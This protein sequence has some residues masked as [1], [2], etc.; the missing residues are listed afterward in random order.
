MNKNW[1]Q[2]KE[3]FAETL[4]EPAAERSRFIV[5]RCAGDKDLEREIKSLLDSYNEANL[6]LESPAVVE[7]AE[8]FADESKRLR[9]GD[10][11][12]HYQI[13]KQI[14]KGGM[15]EVFLAQDTR[16]ERKVA[17]KILSDYF[18]DNR[19]NLKRFIRE[20]KTASSLNHPNIVI[21]HE[22]DEVDGMNFIVSEFIEGLT[23]TEIINKKTLSLA[24]V[25]DILIQIVKALVAAHTVGIIH[26]DIKPDNVMVRDDGI[27]KVLDFGLAKLVEKR[28]Q[29][30]DPNGKTLETIHTRSGMILGT[31][32]YMSPEQT[33]GKGIDKRTDIWSFGVLLYQFLTKKL[34]FDGETTSDLIAS[35]LKS[36]PTALNQIAPHLPL[37]IAKITEKCLQKNP[38]ERFQTAAELLTALTDFQQ[39]LK[40]SPKTEPL[41][42]QIS[43]QLKT[44]R[45][46]DPNLTKITA[47][48]S[49]KTKEAAESL[50]GRTFNQFKKRSTFSITTLIG[51]GL[52]LA[53]GYW[54]WTKIISPKQELNPFQNMRLSKLTYEG[55]SSDVTAISPDGKYIAYV[56]KSD[57]KQAMMVRQVSN[58]GVAEIIPP[59]DADYNGLSFSPDGNSI[60]YTSSKNIT[61]NDLYE[62]P[63]LGGSPQK[64]LSNI[65]P[66]F[67]FSPDGQKL[68]YFISERSLMISNMT[69]ESPQL[70]TTIELEYLPAQISW[71]PDGKAIVAVIYGKDAKFR[72]SEFSLE[73][74]SEKNISDFPWVRINGLKFLADGSG[75]ILAGRDLETQ[76]SQI[77]FVSYPDGKT[78]RITNDLNT[79][80]DLSLTAD[81][82]S[83]VTIKNERIFNIW[84]V[85]NGKTENAKKITFEEGKDEGISGITQTS[86]GKIVYTVR[87]SGH[88]EL[89]IVNKDGSDNHPLISNKNSNYFP[90]ASP[91]NDFIV[92]VSD[93]SGS[94][95]LWRVNIE[96]IDLKV[97]KE[98]PD[99]KEVNPTFSLDGKWIFY[100]QTDTKNLSTIWKMS[101]ETGESIQLTNFESN[102]P[103]VSPDGKTFA[104]LYV[105]NPNE[106]EKIAIVS[107]EG[108]KPIK[109]FDFPEIVKTRFFHWSSDGNS[110]I[111][112]NK[113]SQ[114]DNLWSQPIDG[115]APKQLT[116]FESGQIWKFDLARDGQ[117]FILSRGNESSDV[118]MISDFK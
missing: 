73:D 85:P 18:G 12:K 94:L 42:F 64:I 47:Q 70:L 116:F 95:D 79:Y 20:A 11:V 14:G 88:F 8:D 75:L 86:V 113:N 106:R 51:F 40:S 15:G 31:V 50:V 59:A 56:L 26:R 30:V 93:N 7:V 117:S 4:R 71:R 65:G 74:N 1:Q 48:D 101:L 3:V 108:G 84:T 24:Q 43:D 33:R 25:S 27:V 36:E 97:L 55:R 90:V 112:I 16:L 41:E 22:V 104:C 72:L 110:L 83:L 6:F 92:F 87:K 53:A 34:P 39:K 49:V 28:N 23:L 91:N 68:A 114:A 109:V 17:V 9:N 54:S 38:N 80:L 61:A 78:K 111:Y 102:Y 105:P 5:K 52:L 98:T 89:W 29:Q 77:W 13:I 60:Y 82:K 115:S 62:I 45:D 107:I 10:F 32:N 57:G 35:I 63:V 69:G 19:E 58:G 37:D 99:L 103:A 21:I 67:A 66:Y 81:N 2:V 100:R 118:L 44:D 46:T 76:F 96:G